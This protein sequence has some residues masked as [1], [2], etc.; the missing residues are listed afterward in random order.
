M[1]VAIDVRPLILTGTGVRAAGVAHLVSTLAK[2]L[3]APVVTAWTHDVIDGLTRDDDI[4]I[5]YAVARATDD[6]HALR[7]LA[8]DRHGRVR[9]AASD[10]V[11]ASLAS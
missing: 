6:P 10:R 2:A 5:R 8:A 1:V 3:N 7:V 9:R 4:R 11:F